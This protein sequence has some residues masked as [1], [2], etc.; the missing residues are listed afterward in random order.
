MPIVRFQHQGSFRNTERGLRNLSRL[1][2]KN[3]LS[4]LGQEGVQALAAATP[5]DSRET[6]SSWSYSI[7][8]SRSS[9]SISWTNSHVTSNGVPV[10]ILLQYGHGTGTGGY[11]RG[12]DFINPAIKPVFDRIDATLWKAVTSA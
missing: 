12:R 9:L 10:V 11:V 1:Q 5:V 6:A 4:Q 3:L 8:S 7:R 2:M